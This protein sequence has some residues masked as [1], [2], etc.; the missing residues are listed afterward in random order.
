VSHLRAWDDYTFDHS[1]QVAMLS[2]L[3][4]RELGLTP[5]QLYRLGTGAILHDIGKVAVPKEVLNKEGP[6]T[7]EEFELMKTHCRVGWD[8][9]QD[10]PSIMPT[11]AIVILQHHERL[12]GSGYPSGLKDRDIHLYAKITAVADVFD[13][14][15]ADRPYRRRLNPRA[16]VEALTRDAGPKLNADMVRI[17]LRKVAVVPQGEIVR[18]TNGLIAVVTGNN[19]GFPLEPLVVAFGDAHNRPIPRQ[20]LNLKASGVQVAEILDEWPKDL[21]RSIV[22][23]PGGTEPPQR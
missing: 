2:I 8:I 5:Y 22:P 23:R 21:V 1:V 3:L 18:L 10:H 11:S 13:A 17:L 12:D 14:M 9:I 20:D 4:G 16:V 6:L 7:P 19:P 15:R